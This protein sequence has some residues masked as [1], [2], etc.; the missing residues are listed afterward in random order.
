MRQL[1]IPPNQ[2]YKHHLKFNHFTTHAKIYIDKDMGGTGFIRLLDQINIDKGATI[3]RNRLSDNPS[4]TKTLGILHRNLRIGQ[5][6]TGRRYEAIVS[7]VISWLG[8]S[9]FGSHDFLACILSHASVQE[10]SEIL[11][12]L[13]YLKN[14]A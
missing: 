7:S 2:L 10:A 8:A 3:V 9:V 13:F 6:D 14:D 5:N 1:N 4:M 12:D 11:L